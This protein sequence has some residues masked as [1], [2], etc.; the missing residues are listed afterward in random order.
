MAVKSAC[1]APAVTVIS[2]STSYSTPYSAATLAAIAARNSAT[3]AIGG[4]WF[5][6]SRIARQVASKSAGSAWKSGKPC[7]RLIAPQSAASFDMTVKMV[8][9]TQ[10]SLESMTTDD[11]CMAIR[12]KRGEE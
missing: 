2:L 8:V 1:V 7:D 11:G 12:A 4:Y 6:P 5:L 3:P 9:P 10:G